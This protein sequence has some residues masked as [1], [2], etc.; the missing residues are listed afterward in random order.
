MRASE[1][2]EPS[3]DQVQR[4]RRFVSRALGSKAEAAAPD[5]LLLV[6][7]L[8]T[9]A[10]LHARSDFTVTVTVRKQVVRVEVFDRNTRIPGMPN[11]PTDA[12]SGRGLMLV[13]ALANRWGIE[14][15][16]D[17]GKSVWFELSL[18]NGRVPHHGERD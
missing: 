14:T 15:F 13:K 8:A 5:A 7:E 18:S 11:V 3:A 9:N 1:S 17:Q 10:V 4:A 2:F 6:S 12:A 16:P